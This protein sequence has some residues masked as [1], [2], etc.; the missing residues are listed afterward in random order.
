MTLADL[1]PLV[2]TGLL[3][4]IFLRM[5]SYGSRLD[6][7]ESWRERVRDRMEAA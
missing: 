7:L 6:S 3:A 4:G 5:G 1:V 2:Q